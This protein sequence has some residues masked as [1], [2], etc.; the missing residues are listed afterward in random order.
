MSKGDAH[1]WTVLSDKLETLCRQRSPQAALRVGVIA[2]AIGRR[3]FPADDPRLAELLETLGEI[4]CDLGDHETGANYYAD[5]LAVHEQ[6]GDVMEAARLCQVI[7]SRLWKDGDAERALAFYEEAGALA[8]DGNGG[9]GADVI[10]LHN[11]MALL[12]RQIARH[13]EAEKHYLRALRICEET[14]GHNHPDVATI[15][16]NLGVHYFEQEQ[17]LKAADV[18]AR[19]LQIREEC[20]D[21]P[22]EAIVQSLG[23]L[24]TTC[25]AAGDTADAETIYRRAAEILF[26][27]DGAPT[28]DA[29]T[30]LENYGNLLR[31]A[32]KMKEAAQIAKQ[33]AARG[34][35][36][37][38]RG[39]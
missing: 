2:L 6:R 7:G 28:A 34:A 9:A 1:L 33:A 5:A 17:F 21:I 3:N 8:A 10:S 36:Q 38:R 11:T 29:L 13:D 31:S 20:D 14:N 35:P 4:S 39:G 18:H 26:A 19:A 12:S 24:A 37:F 22:T 30:I 16:G 23:N 32:G 25:H 27:S 15:L